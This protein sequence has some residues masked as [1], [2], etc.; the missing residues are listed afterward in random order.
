M[1]FVA[2]VAIVAVIVAVVLIVALSHRHARAVQQ[3]AVF[4]RKVPEKAFYVIKAGDS[5]SSI[6]VKTGVPMSKLKALNPSV[7][8]TALQAGQRLRLRP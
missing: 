8:P 1:R 5:L 2:P 3:P 6:S 4:H 7:V